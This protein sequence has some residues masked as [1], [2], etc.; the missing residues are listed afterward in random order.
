MHG[1]RQCDGGRFSRAFDH[2]ISQFAL[3]KWFNIIIVRIAKISILIPF[4]LSFE[5]FSH[6]QMLVQSQCG[7]RVQSFGCDEDL[8][9]FLLLF[10]PSLQQ[11]ILPC[12][13]FIVHLPSSV[14]SVPNP[15]L[16]PW[17]MP[18]MWQPEA[19]RS[20]LADLRGLPGPPSSSRNLLGWRW[21]FF[22]HWRW[23][24]YGLSASRCAAR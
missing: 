5:F 4:P 11:H 23:P 2:W 12:I 15:V 7:D 18:L 10:V 8:D 21:H 17:P 14:F 20:V 24:E 16:T 19:S 9:K 22:Y 13:Y 6:S 1:S 3:P